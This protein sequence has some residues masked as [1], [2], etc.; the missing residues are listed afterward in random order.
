MPRV[1]ALWR[2]NP[3]PP[4][5]GAMRETMSEAAHQRDSNVAKAS[6]RNPLNLLILGGILLI[7]AIAIGTSF[8]IVTFRQRALLN[9]ERELQNTV[10][11][12]ARH[13]DRELDNF[14]GI[15][16]DFVRR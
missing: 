13:F 15:Q 1:R 5:R 10:L 8:T 9:S 3:M 7:A 6:E 14:D 2:C 16:R 12:L 4:R 11:L